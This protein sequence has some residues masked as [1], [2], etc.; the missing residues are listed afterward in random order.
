[1][2]YIAT[3]GNGNS[4]LSPLYE[5]EPASG[6]APRRG[7]LHNTLYRQRWLVAAII[8]T[9]LVAAGV[10]SVTIRPYY[11]ATASIMVRSLDLHPAELT[12]REYIP[13]VDPDREMQTELTILGSRAVALPVIR[14]LQLERRDPEIAATLAQMRAA[15]PRK[16]VDAAAVAYG[17]F[18]SK[19]A[20]VPDKLSDTVHVSY[21]SHDAALAAEVVNATDQSFLLESLAE[22]GAQGRSASHW[23]RQQVRA[24]VLQLGQDDAAVAAFQNQHAYVPLLASGAQSALLARLADANHTWSAAEA[25]RISDAADLHS[26]AGNVT[27]LP[28]GVSNPEIAR[29]VD[30]LGAAQAQLSTLT[31]TYQTSFPLVVEA[32]A[33]VRQAQQKLTSLKAEVATGLQQRLAGSQQR[34]QQLAL[35]VRRLNH[36]AAATSGL[37]MRFGVLQARADAQRNLAATLRQKLS[38]VELEASL[39]PS[40]I[41]VLDAAV[42]PSQP[43][44]PRL[45]LD[46]ALGLGLGIVVGM[47]AAL[48]REHW[49]ETLTAGDGVVQALGPALAPLGMIAEKPPLRTR[50]RRALLGAG[51]EQNPD[52][53]R[54]VAANLVARCGVP[55]RTILVTSAN[56]GEGKTTSVCQLGRALAQ[57]GWRTLLVDAGLQ[58]PGCHRFFGLANLNG[59]AAAQTGRKTAPLNVATHLDL[60]PVEDD[61]PPL[62]I[63]AMATLLEQW[64]EHYDYVLLDSP[65]GQVSGDAVLLS[66]LVDGVVVV[67]QWGQTRRSEA[68]QLCEDLARAH[69]PLLGTLFNRAD[70]AAPAFRPYR[71]PKAGAAQG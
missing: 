54:K 62:Q 4:S 67:L 71:H 19:L 23:M 26:F 20:A 48:T 15:R 59:L 44:Y 35:L 8:V 41:Q 16:T 47:G 50:T 53:F 31:T 69:A 18:R 70:P 43:L 5:L 34:A 46:L 1:M 51:A 40:N 36:Q 9:C 66:S 11:Q 14:Q 29:A 12:P 55:P 64:R 10:L 57:A 58:R 17:I 39:P 27:A 7:R 21:S 49:G 28:A 22:R 38:E 3:S 13:A 33:Q 45:G 6:A 63:R 2:A 61:A 60:M 24:A 30:N 37:E 42:P 56:P 52:G 65:P 25:E 68:Q 32:R